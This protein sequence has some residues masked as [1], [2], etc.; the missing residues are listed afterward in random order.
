MRQR[1]PAGGAGSNTTTTDAQRHQ[2]AQVAPA[3]AERR[4][5][6]R[7]ARYE[8]RQVGNARQV[9]E[10]DRHPA[11]RVARGGAGGRTGE[12][13]PRSAAAAREPHGHRPLTEALL[14]DLGS[15]AAHALAGQRR[16]AD[17]DRLARLVADGTA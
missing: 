13:G 15:S 12:V 3:N 16:R 5:D 17:A 2:R 14:V 7:P 11:P 6:Q 1:V 4:R 9:V 8:R 10:H